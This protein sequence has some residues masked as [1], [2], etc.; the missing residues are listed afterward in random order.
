MNYIQIPSFPAYEIAENYSCVR[1][2][3]SQKTLNP[4]GENKWQLRDKDGKRKTVTLEMIKNELPQSSVFFEDE[5]DEISGL[6]TGDQV[7]FEN[8]TGGKTIG[9]IS[10]VYVYKDGKEYAMVEDKNGKKIQKRT[11]SLNKG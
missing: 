4:L 11:S 5:P 2:V 3:S 6:K 10:R 1:S 7:W 8:K 9:N